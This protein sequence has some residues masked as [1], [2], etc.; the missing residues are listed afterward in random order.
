MHNTA[1]FPTKPTWLRAVKNRQYASWPGLMPKTIAKHFPE[2]KETLKGHAWKTR[3]GQQWT[4]RMPVREDNLINENEAD[5]K[6]G[7]TRPTTKECNIFTQIYNVE[8]DEAILKMYTDQ[9]GR[10][11]KKSS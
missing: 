5:T 6:A 1:G 9:T 11:P 3:S 8:E 4:K 10:F 2:S 7:L